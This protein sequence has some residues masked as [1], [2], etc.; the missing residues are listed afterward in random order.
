METSSQSVIVPLTAL[1]Q[2]SAEAQASEMGILQKRL[3]NPKHYLQEFCTVVCRTARQTGHTTAIAQMAAI[4]EG[5]TILLSQ[6][7]SYSDRLYKKGE[8][9]DGDY[10]RNK[11]VYCGTVEDFLKNGIPQ[12]ETRISKEL[13]T[14]A[15]FVDGASQIDDNEIE[16]IYRKCIKLSENKDKFF[17]VLV[18]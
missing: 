4:M 2:L 15:V 9:I 13:E 11:V 12:N 5:K 17:I 3:S 16:Q 8:A 18:G 1:I 7:R 14:V 6:Y 10:F